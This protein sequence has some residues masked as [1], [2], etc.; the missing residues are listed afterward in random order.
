DT[1]PSF[2]SFL[3]SMVSFPVI[4]DFV[5]LCSQDINATELGRMAVPDGSRQSFTM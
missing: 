5:Y 2:S 3:S 1:S 4:S